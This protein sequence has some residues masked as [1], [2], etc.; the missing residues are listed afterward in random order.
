MIEMLIV[1]A[2]MMIIMAIALPNFIR[3]MHTSRVRTDTNNLM[4]LLSVARL[5][6]ASN[7]ARAQVKCDT[8][9]RVCTLTTRRYGTNWSS[10]PNELQSVRLSQDVTFSIPSGVTGAGNQTT[11]VQGSPGQSNPYYIEFNSRGM[12]IDHTTGAAVNNF[13]LYVADTQYGVSMAI[14]VDATGRILS[15]N[16]TGSTYVVVGQ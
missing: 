15:Y 16:K 5:R 14:A 11:A 13:A 8:T 3:G 6:A 1:I 7:F 4:G 12:P 2:I 10:T 9:T